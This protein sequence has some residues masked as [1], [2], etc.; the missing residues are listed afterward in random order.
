MTD[1]LTLNRDLPANA[2]QCE[3]VSPLVRRIVAPNPSA[4]TFTGTCS[5]II[6]KGEV[7]ILDPGPLLPEHCDALL[8]AVSGETVT[9]IVITHTHR[10]HSPAAAILKQETGAIVAGCHPNPLA[11]PL[12][13]GEADPLTTNSDGNYKP[14]LVLENGGMLKGRNWS[15]EA[16]ETPGHTANHLSFRLDEENALFSGDHVMAWSTTVIS[17]PE[18][19]MSAYMASLEKLLQRDEQI[20][21]P[22]HGG[23]V[24][25]PRAFLR[26]LLLHR[27]AR[28]AAI[29]RRLKEGDEMI[30]QIVS[31]LYPDIPE[32]L[33]G[34][35]ANSVFAHLE[36]LVARELVVTEGFPRGDGLYRAV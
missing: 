35:A 18:G 36:D 32:T 27:R 13:P 33:V 8:Q 2:G 34:A 23:P 19:S 14:D 31:A 21:W 22:G 25:E 3:K 26:A 5:Y 11:R 12:A 16:V 29:L 4:Y 7:A 17:P 15:L 24:R 9:H 1:D 20:Y 6:G 10:D 30:P 28:E